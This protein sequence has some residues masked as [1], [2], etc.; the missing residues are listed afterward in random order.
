MSK[1]YKIKKDPEKEEIVLI[2]NS[3]SFVWNEEA[4]VDELCDYVD[5]SYMDDVLEI[6]R[7]YTESKI[8]EVL[9]K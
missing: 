7:S 1:E 9:K 2:N 5:L 8:K 6:I 4:L 3:E